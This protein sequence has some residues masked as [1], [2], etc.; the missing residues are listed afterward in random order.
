[1]G[2]YRDYWQRGG[3]ERGPDGFANKII[4]KRNYPGNKFLSFLLVEGDTDRIFYTT[5]I[6][7]DK[8]QIY[9]TFNKATVIQVLLIL[10]KQAFPGVLAIV[11]ADFDIL[12]GRLS[13]SPN[14]CYTDT[15]DLETM[16][17]KS[18]ALEKVLGAFGSAEKI[19]QLLSKTGKDLRTLL[20]ECGMFIGYLRWISLQKQLSLVF[21][22]LNFDKFTHKETLMINQLDFIRVVKNKSQRL[23]I[24]EAQLTLSIQDLQSDAHDPWHVCC[25]HDLVCV[26]SRGLHGAIGR[27]RNDTKNAT[28]E[29]LE[30]SLRLAFEHSHFYKTSLYASIQKWETAN[31]PY[32]ILVSG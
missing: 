30:I 22:D 29:M 19:K 10:E 15:H 2:E 28:P 26:L 9:S 31:T 23:D 18:P 27:G 21:E 1:M 20:L 25:G 8:C 5:F 11:D 12:E 17:L 14:M 16:I 4:S 13:P 24:A 32:V 6:D 7:Q 3:G